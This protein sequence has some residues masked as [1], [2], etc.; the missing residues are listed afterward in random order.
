MAKLRKE[1]VIHAHGEH[2]SEQDFSD[3]EDN[4]D[5]NID[6]GNSGSGSD[7]S[8]EEREIC[9]GINNS[10]SDLSLSSDT[11]DDSDV[12]VVWS[13][14][15]PGFQPQKS[16]CKKIMHYYSYTESQFL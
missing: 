8:A 15:N 7:E 11:E 5:C 10:G 14:V 4:S 12:N 3:S 2:D 1:E 9:K 13:G 6:T 16:I